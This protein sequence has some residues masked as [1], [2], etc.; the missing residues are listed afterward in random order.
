[1]V[2]DKTKIYDIILTINKQYKI[3]G[4]VM[5]ELKNEI[6]NIYDYLTVIG[7]AGS[8]DAYATWWCKCKCGNVIEV[9]GVNLRRSGTKSCGCL[10]KEK[11]KQMND[12]KLIDLTGE[13]FG[14]LVV[15]RRGANKKEQPTWICQCECGAITEVIGAN[16]RKDNGTW[17]CGCINSK[18]EY[19]I[20]QILNDNGIE[21]KR[22][23][24]FQDCIS[25]IGYQL[26][27]D[28]AIIK[29]NELKCLIEY[30]GVQHYEENSFMNRED[31]NERIARDEIKKEYCSKNNIPLIIIPYTH[32]DNICIDDLLENSK[33][34]Y[35]GEIK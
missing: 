12:D 2:L 25:D 13:K 30:Q 3:N 31:F 22:E 14:R 7:R 18:G 23:F 21:F 9:K 27:F 4:D 10:Q 29:N 24:K 8:K 32:F 6:G 33:F 1:M 34:I 16:L 17:S 26:R 15:L 5:A 35:K 20:S 11:V 19:K 28:F